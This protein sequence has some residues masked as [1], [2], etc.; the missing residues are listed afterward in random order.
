MRIRQ[1]DGL[2]AVAALAVVMIHVSAGR[3]NPVGVSC[4]QIARFA[5]PLFIM[6]SGYGPVSYTHLTLP[7]NSLV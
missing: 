7:T 2:R 1:M 4:N 3:M 5:V 6:L